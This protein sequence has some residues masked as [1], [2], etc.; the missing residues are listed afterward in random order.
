MQR[1]LPPIRY[2]RVSLSTEVIVRG[3][4]R[5]TKGHEV[6]YRD[7]VRATIVTIVELAHC[8]RREWGTRSN[9]LGT[10]DAGRLMMLFTFF[11][12]LTPFIYPPAYGTKTRCAQVKVIGRSFPKNYLCG[13]N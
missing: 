9:L 10:L 12:S 1:V 5:A 4:E 6:G 13:R 8:N 2:S 11:L 7:D 3:W